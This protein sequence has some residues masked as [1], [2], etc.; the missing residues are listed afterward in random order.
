MRPLCDIRIAWSDDSYEV[1][2]EPKASALHDGI[3][4]RGEP[5]GIIIQDQMFVSHDPFG[6]REKK[7]IP[8]DEGY[9]P[10]HRESRPAPI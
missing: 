5:A 6:A 4:W 9:G 2:I 1:P 7:P 10:S 8:Q 3:G